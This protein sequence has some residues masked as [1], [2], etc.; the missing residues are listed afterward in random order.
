MAIAAQVAV[1]LFCPLCGVR[2]AP[3]AQFCHRCGTAMPDV[4]GSTRLRSVP[5]INNYA[6]FWDRTGAMLIDWVVVNSLVWPTS[7]VIGWILSESRRMIGIRAHDA[8]FASGFL[9]VVLWIVA[10][11]LYASF[12]LSSSR[13]ATIGKQWMR[14]KVTNSEGSRIS[15]IQATGRHFAKFLSTFILLGGF[16]MAAFTIK[17]QALHDI[18][19]D[20]IVVSDR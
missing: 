5:R 19:A 4:T 13:Q 14:L 16:V 20:T 2:T 7:F 1:S 9:A 8:S 10:D 18:A 6:P 3:S 15:F 12:M 11:W 17:R